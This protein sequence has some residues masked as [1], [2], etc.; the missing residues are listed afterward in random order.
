M[1][2][3]LIAAPLRQDVDVF[4]EYQKGLDSLEVPEGFTVNRFFVIN[5]CPEIRAEVRDAKT[6]EVETGEVYEKTNN[7]HLWSLDLMLKM[8]TLRNMTI[9]EM[10]EGG[11]DYWFSVDTDIVLDPWTLYHLIQADK[12]IVSEIFWT[13]APNGNYWCN[14][15][16]TD[17][18][19]T[20]REE[21]HKPGLYQVGMTGACT[22]VKRR[23]F[24]AGVDYSQIPNIKTALRGEDRHFCVRAACAG[25][26]M[27]IDTHA[28]ATHL[29][30]RKVYEQ[31]M[32]DKAGSD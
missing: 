3:I 18:Y 4:R 5:D 1:K 10:L 30:T 7:D 28:P 22:L 15:W 11:Y 25:F 26:E 27:W 21:W 29:Y 2:K 6:V 23:V 19:S 17:Q 13:Q 12:D 32:K 14:A 16:M 31:Y 9:R 20:P 8:G 24:E